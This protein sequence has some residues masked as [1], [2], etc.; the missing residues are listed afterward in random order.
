[1]R[2]FQQ[3]RPADD[4]PTFETVLKQY[5]RPIYW[6]IRRMVVS[7]EDAQDVMQETFIRVYQGLNKLRK[8]ELLKV[9]VYRIATNECLRHLTKVRERTMA[10]LSEDDLLVRRLEASE[11]VDWEDVEGVRLQ[12]AILRLSQQERTVFNMRYYDEMSYE[13]ISQVT[14]ST[15]AT[16][17]VAF[18]HAKEKI[19]QELFK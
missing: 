4:M 10:E 5:E 19:K 14:G 11:H 7:H 8:K 2:L 3:G 17:K 13:E 1:M 6:H 9:W 15:V 16:L 12:K 18:H